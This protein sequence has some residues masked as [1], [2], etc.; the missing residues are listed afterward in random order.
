MD[1]NNPEDGNQSPLPTTDPIITPPPKKPLNSK[2]V[3][4]IILAIT[5]LA[6]GVWYLSKH[7]VGPCVVGMDSPCNGEQFKQLPV[8]NQTPTP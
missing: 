4:V 2:F 3:A 6:A 5:A 7:T 1:V 8:K